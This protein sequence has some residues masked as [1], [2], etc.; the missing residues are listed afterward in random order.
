MT[1]KTIAV[2]ETNGVATIRLSRADQMNAL[3]FDMIDELSG[4]LSQIEENGDVRSLV[5][6]GEGAAFCAGA[7]L[8]EVLETVGVP[9]KRDFL[10]A[11]AALFLRIRTL[12]VP[13]IGGLNGITM[14]GGLEL[15]MCCDVLIAGESARI[16]DAHSNFGVFPGAGGAA[17]LPERIGLN[18]A[19]YLLF[20]GDALPAQ[21]LLEM[22]L[23]QE[24]VADDALD[25]RLQE[26]GEKLA[27]KSPLVLRRM[28][29][30]A[31]Q[32]M[33]MSQSGAL[34]LE[35]ETLR[36]HFRSDDLKEGLAAFGE[37]RKPVFT[38]Q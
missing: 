7:D 25:A 1:Y 27:A 18:N 4:A 35:L 30:V 8:K 33:E 3:S 38:G 31:N 11:I 15:A 13:V 6:T 37:K 14:A 34:Q 23:V 32:S 28:K 21:R 17:V 36:N 29:S 26:F 9:G 19:K 5:V 10:D 12:P 2:N 22:G 24:V 20:T 16:G